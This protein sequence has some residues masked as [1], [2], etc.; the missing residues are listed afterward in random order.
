MKHARVA[1]MSLLSLPV[2]LLALGAAAND[3]PAHDS[4]A[5][6]MGSTTFKTFCASC[7]GKTARGDGPLAEH[8][9]FVPPDLTRIAKRNGG[10]F[11]A[12][13]VAKIIDGRQA[14]K[15]HGGSDMPVW[16]DAFLRSREG[17]DAA[18]VKEKIGELVHFLASLQE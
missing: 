6:L 15:G 7:H 5:A 17:Y 8:L 14:V 2:G 13:K 18:K 10:T 4:G 9:R 16:G 12:E 1:C 3:K 11:D